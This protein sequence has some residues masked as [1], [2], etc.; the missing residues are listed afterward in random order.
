[1]TDRTL[2]ERLWNP[3][4]AA[5]FDGKDDPDIAV[6]ELTATG[7]EWWDGPNSKIGQVLSIV[8]TAV[9]GATDDDEH[10]EIDV[11]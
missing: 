3:A 6:L 5:Y 2:I 7:G 11:R 8:L 9:R 10:G 1:M 4:A